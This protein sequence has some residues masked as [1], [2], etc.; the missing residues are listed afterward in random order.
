MLDYDGKVVNQWNNHKCC[1][2]NDML[3][4]DLCRIPVYYWHKIFVLLN[5][6]NVT[7]VAVNH[8]QHSAC[9]N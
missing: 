3:F 4:Q 9:N 7:L 8:A 1:H 6:I 5:V 2:S